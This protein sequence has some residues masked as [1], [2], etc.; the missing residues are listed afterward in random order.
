ML[1]LNQD[2]VLSEHQILFT[3]KYSLYRDR[4][5]HF[6]GSKWHRSI[7]LVVP[8]NSSQGIGLLFVEVWAIYHLI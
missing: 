4:V 5:A 1:K 2:N 7:N 8:L 6:S 3:W